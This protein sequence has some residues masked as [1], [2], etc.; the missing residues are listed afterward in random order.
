M[1]LVPAATVM[2]MDLDGGHPDPRQF[3][4]PFRQVGKI[5]SY[6]IDPDTERLNYDEIERW[7]AQSGPR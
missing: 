3:R 1:P 7:P 4:Q 2:G 5:V 6:G